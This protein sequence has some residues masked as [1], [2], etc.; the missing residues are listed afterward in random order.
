MVLFVQ[1]WIDIRASTMDENKI[2]NNHV[3]IYPIFQV[4][5][6]DKVQHPLIVHR[7]LIVSK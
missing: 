2:A 5:D 4:L 7:S 6:D 3:V 1:T